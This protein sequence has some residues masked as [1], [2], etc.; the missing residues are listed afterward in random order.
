MSIHHLHGIESWLL[1]V[2]LNTKFNHNP[3]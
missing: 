1:M 2:L 3:N